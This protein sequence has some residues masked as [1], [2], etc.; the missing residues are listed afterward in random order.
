MTNPRVQAV[1]GRRRSNAAGPHG[2]RP[3]RAAQLAEALDDWDDSA[4]AP[5]HGSDDVYDDAAVA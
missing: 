4:D 5:Q 3:T 1:Q 2:T